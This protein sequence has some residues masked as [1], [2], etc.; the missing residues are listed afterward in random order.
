MT[1]TITSA[2]TS[3]NKSKVPALFGLADR[4]GAWLPGTLNLDFGGGRYDTASEWMLTRGVVSLVYDPYNRT[5]EHNQGVIDAIVCSGGADTVTCSNVLNVIRE[6]DARD[7]VIRGCY[8]A[9]KAGGTVYFTVYEGD[10]TGVGRQTG[11]D[12]WQEN[13]PTADYMQEVWKW[14]PGAYRAGKLIIAPDPN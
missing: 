4:R 12:Q 7:A 13:R 2:R 10:G 5:D 8:D 9:L 14:F 3:I 6:P 1:Q 11:A